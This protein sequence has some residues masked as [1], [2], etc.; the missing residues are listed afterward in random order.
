MITNIVYSI[1]YLFLIKSNRI[2][3]MNQ[4][5]QKRSAFA[6]RFYEII[7]FLPRRACFSKEA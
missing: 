3:K 1:I 2:S 6:D 5:K 7:C 4:N